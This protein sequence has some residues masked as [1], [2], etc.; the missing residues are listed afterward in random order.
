MNLGEHRG[1]EIGQRGLVAVIWDLGSGRAWKAPLSFYSDISRSMN[2][3][4][5]TLIID[6]QGFWCSHK[7]TVFFKL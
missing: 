6:C 7:T 1:E 5:A 4:S 3:P 2:S